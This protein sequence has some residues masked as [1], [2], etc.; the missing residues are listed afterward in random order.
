MAK[1]CPPGKVW[2]GSDYG[3]QNPQT[4]WKK[5]APGAKVVDFNFEE[6]PFKL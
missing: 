5:Q 3:C 2:A 6:S 1:S 4:I